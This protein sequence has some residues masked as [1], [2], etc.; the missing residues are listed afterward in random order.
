[1]TMNYLGLDR[2]DHRRGLGRRH[3]V[4][5]YVGVRSLEKIA[6]SISTI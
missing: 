1:M 3:C 5:S 2:R 4:T 6:K